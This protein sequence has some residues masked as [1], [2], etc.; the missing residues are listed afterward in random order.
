MVAHW[1][2]PICAK[3][4]CAEWF[5]NRSSLPVEA[6]QI[7]RDNLLASPNSISI[8]PG[9]SIVAPPELAHIDRQ[10]GLTRWSSTYE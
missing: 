8:A 10:S 7:E 9:R 6:S 4:K 5:T 1:P 2:G 3:K